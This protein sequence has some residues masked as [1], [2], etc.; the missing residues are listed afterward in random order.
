MLVLISVRGIEPAI[1]GRSTACKQEDLLV[2]LT[3]TINNVY[4]YIS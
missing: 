1:S 3:L 4:E 2:W